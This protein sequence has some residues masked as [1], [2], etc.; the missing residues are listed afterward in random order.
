MLIATW[1]P[2]V[3]WITSSD[4]ARR[5]AGT[6]ITPSVLIRPVVVS[7]AYWTAGASSTG[8]VERGACPARS[9]SSYLHFP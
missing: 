1:S 3:S 7:A 2:V 5:K 8:H 4:S 6:T 9:R